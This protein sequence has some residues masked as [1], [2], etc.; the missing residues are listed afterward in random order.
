MNTQ[1]LVFALVSGLS[2]LVG[3][4]LG[5]LRPW[6]PK[7]IARFM[8]FGSGVLI[9]ALTFG[10]MEEAF[11]H[12][13]FDAVI[14]GFLTGGAT[15]I[16]GDYVLHIKGGRRHKRRPIHESKADSSSGKIIA[17]GALL[18]GIP[19][20]IALG[21]ALFAG[22]AQGVLMLSAIAL[23]NFPEGISSVEGLKREGFSKKQIYILWTV[24]GLLC[25]AA[26]IISYLFLKEL[27]LNTIGILESFAAGAIL[28]MIADSMMPEAFEEGGFTIAIS[29]VL[30]FL[31]AFILAKI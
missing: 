22:G 12:G 1:V 19:E 16:L 7:S 23:S 4:T 10:L 24:V 13:G 14:I 21:I 29:T 5:I 31:A 18:D 26:V 8:A 20:S 27:N 25:T 2:L 3:A 6:K 15:F 28:A 9:C 11:S 17:L 30:G